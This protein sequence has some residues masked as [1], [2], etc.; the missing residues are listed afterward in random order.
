MKRRHFLQG[1]ASA[2]AAISLS[3]T[4]FRHQADR[5]GRV[6]AQETPRKLALLV[7]IN[8]YPDPIIGDL[9]GCVTDVEMQYHLLVHRFGF[10]PDD[11]LMLTTDATEDWRQPTRA[12]IINAFET[13]L[14]EQAG[15][16]DVVVFHYSGHGST[17]QDP[18]PIT[19]AA[20]GQPNPDGVNGTLVPI[21]ITSIGQ[22]GEE[23]VVPDIMGRSLFLLMARLQTEHQTVVLDSCFSGAGTRGT[24]RVRAAN[25]RLSRA[26]VT[27]VASEE[28]LEQQRRWMTDLG[29]DEEAFRQ[30]RAL[31]IAKGVALGSASCNQ[32]ALEFPYDQGKSA[33]TFT[34]LLTSYLWQL[35]TT[36][37]VATLQANLIRATK[38]ATVLHKRHLQVPIFEYKPQSHHAQQPLYFLEMTRPFADGVIITVMG[39]QIEF[40]LGDCPINI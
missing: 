28:E 17:V 23:I 36:E 10:V 24:G 4:R 29:L 32:L 12:N 16:D 8:H 1:S 38:A 11:I 7:G 2:L 19:V 31:G 39:E 30:R 40:W 22:S 18:S 14:I 5:Y 6:L 3:Q 20:C 9:K 21:D 27:L 37:M 25:S 35:P 34:Y 13:H 15:P 33:G 26:G